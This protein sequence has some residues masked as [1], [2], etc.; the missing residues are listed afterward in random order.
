MYLLRG[1]VKQSL[2][3]DKQNHLTELAARAEV[4]AETGDI[5]GSYQIVKG[6]LHSGSRPLKTIRDET[7]NLLTSREDVTQR[8]IRHFAGV[9]GAAT[10]KLD[11]VCFPDPGTHGN[12]PPVTF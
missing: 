10:S 1:A 2:R 11:S 8:W 4:C 7:G 9:F 6:L 5:R 3:D 12:I